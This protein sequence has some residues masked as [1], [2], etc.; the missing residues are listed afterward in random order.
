MRR[1]CALM[2]AA[3]LGSTLLFSG[4][5]E[6]WNGGR[7]GGGWHGGGGGWNGGGWRGGGWNGGGWNRGG[8]AG[9]G[10][11]GGWAG[12][13]GW[14]G[15]GWNRGWAGNPGWRAGWA[16][17]RGGWPGY[18]TGLGLGWAATS[19]YWGWNSWDNWNNTWPYNSYYGTGYG[20]GYRVVPRYAYGTAPVVTGRS[21]AATGSGMHCATPVKT[22]LLYS[23]SFVGNGCSCK[24]TGGRARGSVTP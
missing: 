20:Y 4:P 14:R 15:G 16:W 1:F 23:A 22:C 13:P 6:A 9:S 10:W 18:S 24:V 12:N 17:N 8:W 2:V 5:A 11:N 19:P 21:V 7:G 3:V